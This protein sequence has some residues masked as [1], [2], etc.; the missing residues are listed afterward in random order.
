MILTIRNTNLE[1]LNIDKFHEYYTIKYI[2][3]L[4][5]ITL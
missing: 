2:N 5:D 1:N 4:L 3:K